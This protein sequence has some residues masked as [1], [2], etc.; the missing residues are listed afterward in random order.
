MQVSLVACLAGS[1]TSVKAQQVDP[2]LKQD[3]LADPLEAEPRDP[4]LPAVGVDREYSPLENQ[5][6]DERLDQLDAIAQQALAT[7][8]V[9]KAFELWRR[10]LKLRRVLSIQEE[11]AAIQRVTPIAWEQQRGVDVQLLTLRT[12]EIWNAT[13]A[14]LGQTPDQAS[15]DNTDSAA[16]G[17]PSDSLISGAQTM[18][19]EVLTN[20]ANTFLT[21]RDIDSAVDVYE[22]LIELSAEGGSE[23]A[24]RQRRLAALHLEWFRFAEAADLYLVLLEKARG[25]DDQTLEIEYLE[26]LVYS[27]QQADSLTNAVRA[28]TDLV[29]LYQA[30][31]DEEVLPGLLVAIAKNYRALNLYNSAIEYYRAA[32]A[33]A[34]RY[35]Q[36]SFSA[37][38]LQDL[39]A[40]YSA[41]ALTDEALS[42]YTLLVPVQQQAYNDYGIMNAY[43]NIGQLQK[44]K[45]D[46]FEALKAFQRALVIADRLGLREAY[47]IEQIESVT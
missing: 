29:G 26:Q 8:Q 25:D 18:D 9:N 35:D 22:Q 31:G 23:R 43:D 11:F 20:V 2:Q 1:A 4:L 47:F 40:L 27:Y 21:L 12:R 3:F 45:G 36:F 42:A 46:N 17:E 33:A 14:S 30:R 38:V 34:Q 24:N 41:L 10:E 5:A 13:Q 15:D 37:Q 39:G 19:V 6:I 28:Q 16:E 44:R 7:G 32:Y